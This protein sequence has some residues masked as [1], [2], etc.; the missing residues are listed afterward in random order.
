MF[1]IKEINCGKGKLLNERRARLY[2]SSEISPKILHISYT[3]S[4]QGCFISNNGKAISFNT[5]EDL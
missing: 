2:K 4:S 1:F 5:Y 3:V